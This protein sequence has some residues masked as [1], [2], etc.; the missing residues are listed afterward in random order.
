[1]LA[2]WSDEGWEDIK[3]YY[4]SK[5][6]KREGPFEKQS[7]TNLQRVTKAMAKF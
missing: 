1:M 5:S 3:D 4:L 6:R 2:L 7:K